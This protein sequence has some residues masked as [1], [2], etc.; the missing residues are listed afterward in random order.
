MAQA[1]VDNYPFATK[2][3][4]VIPLDIIRPKGLIMQD[5]SASTGENITIPV[6]SEIAILIATEDCI[7]FEA[8]AT[9]ANPIVS[10]T[11]YTKALFVPKGI[12]VT[13]TIVAGTAKVLGQG[14][15]GKLSIQVVEKWA[16]LALDVQYYKR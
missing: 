6:G 7:F 8:S 14:V 5:F 13:V 10:G 12:A 16:G 2:D 11:Y 9:S 4:K 1:P 15:A 3:G